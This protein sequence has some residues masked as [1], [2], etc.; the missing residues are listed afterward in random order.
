MIRREE[1]LKICDEERLILHERTGIGTYMEKRLHIVLKKYMDPDVTHHEFPMLG[2]VADIF[3]GDT[4]TEIQTGAL[5]PLYKKIKRYVD[6][7][8]YNIKVVCPI[9]EKKWVSWID[10]ESGEVGK[11][12]HS[13]RRGRV[14]D[15]LPDLYYLLEF[16]PTGRLTLCLVMLEI[17]EYRMLDG[18][19]YDKK[20]GS[21]RHERIPVDIFSEMEF[22]GREDYA[23]L[24]P[25]ML[26]E[27]FTAKDFSSAARLSP[28]KTQYSLRSLLSL[29][30]IE[31]A[32][33]DGN[34]FIYKRK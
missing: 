30:L 14:S 8:D 12:S 26:G 5:R 34:A 2:S 31:K 3:D 28:R 13:S 23:A 4:I 19:S 10:V 7:T 17:E 11:K 16:I 24:I 25:E 9:T 1:F 29:E 18:W 21:T 15:I 33:K 32:G 20:R 6:M 22:V 27:T